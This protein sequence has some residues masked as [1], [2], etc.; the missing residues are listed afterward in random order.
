MRSWRAVTLLI[1]LLA[2]GCSGRGS[3]AVA[4]PSVVATPSA[5]A[6][7]ALEAVAATPIATPITTAEDARASVTAPPTATPTFRATPTVRPTPTIAPSSESHGT[8]TPCIGT[9]NSK[10]GIIE[11]PTL[12]DAALWAKS[13]FVGQVVKIGAAHWSHDDPDMKGAAMDWIYT[14]VVMSVEHSFRGDKSVGALVSV[15][16][17]G[18]VVG[19]DGYFIA[20]LSR[21]FVAGQ[22]YVVFLIDP[23]LLPAAGRLA[24]LYDVHSGLV[25]VFDQTV[26]INEVQKVVDS[27]GY[28]PYP[29]LPTPRP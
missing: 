1:V 8:P 5:V 23:S 13:A 17:A 6:T 10:F 22:E 4:T 15:P 25:K 3:T 28:L 12:E 27:V 9:V 14:P 18:G 21:E 7:P 11:T 20:G 26:P 2:G 29:S 19:C 16:V 24:G